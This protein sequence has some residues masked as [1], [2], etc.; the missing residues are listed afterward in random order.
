VAVKS[1]YLVQ[2]ETRLQIWLWKD[3][4]LGMCAS[5]ADISILGAGGGKAPDLAMEGWHLGMCVVAVKS[6]CWVQV[7]GDLLVYPNRMSFDIMEGGGK[8]PEPVGLLVCKVKAVTNLKGGGDLFSK[9]VSSTLA[10]FP[11]AVQGRI[12][13]LLYAKIL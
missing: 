5:G 1:A 3:G 13:A 10:Y 8:A 7:L 9:V 12:E 2:V 11:K 4:M 6:A